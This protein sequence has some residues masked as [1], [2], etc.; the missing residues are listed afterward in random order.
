VSGL[1]GIRSDL[2]ALL[3]AVNARCE[4]GEG[5][6]NGFQIGF[7]TDPWEQEIIG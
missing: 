1:R 6:P 5:P 4:F 2:Q 3:D 7:E